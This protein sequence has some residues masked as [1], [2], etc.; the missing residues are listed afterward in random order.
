MQTFNKL[1]SIKEKKKI[2]FGLRKNIN[3]ITSNTSYISM[4]IYEKNATN[5]F[6]FFS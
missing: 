2:L 5:Y 3:I 6:L 1:L 4:Y